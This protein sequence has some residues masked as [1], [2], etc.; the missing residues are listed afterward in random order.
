MS[1]RMAF[2]YP[3]QFQKPTWRRVRWLTVMAWS[4]LLENLMGVRHL[5]TMP[6]YSWI[7]CV[8]SLQM[9][10]NKS[11]CS[12][13]PLHR[14]TI[15]QGSDKVK[16]SGEEKANSKCPTSTGMEQRY[17]IWWE[18][19]QSRQGLDRDHR[20]KGYWSTT[21]MWACNRTRILLCYTCEVNKEEWSQTSRKPWRGGHQAGTPFV[22]GSQP[23][24]QK[25]VGHLQR[26]WCHAASSPLYTSINS[27]SV[28]DLWNSKEEEMLSNT[29]TVW[30]I[31]KTSEG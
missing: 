8:K 7:M 6:M 5:A 13:W 11:W 22:W 9:S 30:E 27:R 21:T 25:S 19:G 20:D 23:G 26:Y 28:D 24:I 16:A 1:W 17:C 31:C 3:R 15:D 29:W 10:H 2:L 4:K 18:Q 14:A 12:I